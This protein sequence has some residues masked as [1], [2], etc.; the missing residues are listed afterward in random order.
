VEYCCQPRQ[1]PTQHPCRGQT[2]AWAKHIPD[3][4]RTLPENQVMNPYL[5]RYEAIAMSA[6]NQVSVSQAWLSDRHCFQDTTPVMSMMARP[7]SAAATALMPMAPPQIQSPTVRPSASAVI[8]SSVLIVPRALSSSRAWG[9]G[10]SGV[11]GWVGC[12]GRGAGEP[13]SSLHGGWSV[14][15]SR[16]AL[17]AAL[18]ACCAC[19]APYVGGAPPQPTPRGAAINVEEGVLTLAGA[20]GV[21]LT[22][23]G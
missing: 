7:V 8:F 6:A 3:P 15:A 12:W 11:G 5:L 16:A 10:G 1:Q 19:A 20:S 18:S 17:A 14:L 22:S 4:G 23:G 9:Q 13:A 2:P 21:S